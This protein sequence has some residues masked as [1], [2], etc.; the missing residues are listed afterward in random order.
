M[1]SPRLGWLFVFLALYATYCVFW[2]VEAARARRGAM[3]FF[4]S[5]RDI[6][7]WVFAAWSTVTAFTGWMSIG[8]P[9]TIF[10]D[11]FPGAALALG[12]ITIPLAGAFVMARL[13]MISRRFGF[14]TLAEIYA[15][16][17]GGWLVRPLVL[18]I[19]ALFTLPFLG[20]QMAASGYLLQVLSDGLIPWV[21]GM[22]ALGAL[23]FVCVVLGGLRAAASIGVLQA[24]L[25]AAGI[26][27]V[28][29]I[30]WVELGD[31][32]AFVDL[33]A[34]LGGS[35]AGTWTASSGGYNAYLATPGVV[36]FVAGFGKEAPVGGAWTTTMALSSCL[37]LMG[38]PL[39]P[40]FAILVFAARDA[41]GLG[42]QQVW[43]SGAAVGFGLVFFSV[44]AGVGAL[45][46]GASADTTKAGLAVAQTMPALEGGHE[47]GLVAHYLNSLA[48]RAPWFLGLLGVAS[49]AATQATASLYISAAGTMFARD[50]YGCY[51]K[52]DASDNDQKFYG[53]VGVGFTML[54][55]LLFATYAP[56]AQAEIGALA[57]PMALQ[58]LPLALAVSWFSWITP[59]AAISGLVA[60]LTAVFFT[61]SLGLSL[62]SFFEIEIPWGRWP[63]TFHSAGWGIVLNV[64]VVLLFS[65]LTQKRSAR[66]RRMRYHEFLAEATT[67]PANLRAWRPIAWAAGLG[68]FF[69]AIGPGALFGVDLFG[70]P[71]GG[72]ASWLF[73]IPSLWAWQIIAW[74]LGVLLLWLIAYRLGL[75]QPPPRPIEPEAEAIRGVGALRARHL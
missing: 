60:G 55:A 18:A 17:F 43:L 23:V 6:P 63:W 37:A 58:L 27:A 35:K 68:W 74:A 24:L 40:P 44:I 48:T 4:L 14:V 8:A 22:W 59:T 61:D 49:V 66:E 9:A 53:R 72:A 36:Q 28:G 67:R 12:A 26:A 33:L 10:R 71:N 47:A 73:G 65:L 46:L 50:F 3:D 7:A 41:R 20:M 25:F 38:L 45:F 1:I 75:S 69:F 29:V 54:F 13:W 15:D 34:K 52:P 31:F 11:G 62:A 51:L 56:R 42:P 19:A 2:G 64:A 16:Y 32:G 57:L 30:A 70:A 21:F 5:E 39:A